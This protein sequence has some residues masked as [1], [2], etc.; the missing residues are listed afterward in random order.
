MTVTLGEILSVAAW[1]GTLIVGVFAFRGGIEKA[2]QELRDQVTGLRADL[3]AQLGKLDTELRLLGQAHGTEASIHKDR[4]AHAEGVCSNLGR[5]LGKLESRVADLERWQAAEMA[6]HH[7][8]RFS[9]SSVQAGDSGMS[10][11]TRRPGR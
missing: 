6:P 4:L 1:V 7:P 11:A 8:E 3:T 10:P 2:R 9:K 5:D